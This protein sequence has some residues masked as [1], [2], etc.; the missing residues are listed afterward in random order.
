MTNRL[1]QTT[2]M[3]SLWKNS[4]SSTRSFDRVHVGP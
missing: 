2:I 1:S 3:F 4:R